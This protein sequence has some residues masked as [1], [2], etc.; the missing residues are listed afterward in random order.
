V[1]GS[2]KADVRFVRPDVAMVYEYEEV[3]GQMDPT[4]GKQMPTRKI[5]HQYVV[6]KKDGKW[7]IQTEL[8]MDEEHFAKRNSNAGDY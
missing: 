1:P 7:L 2:D 4:I 6:S 3:I 5:H 8:I